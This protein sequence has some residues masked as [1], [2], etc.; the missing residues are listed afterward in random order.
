MIER[1][2]EVANI[3]RA[4]LHEMNFS[5]PHEA[6]SLQN[7]V[8]SSMMDPVLGLALRWYFVVFR[9]LQRNASTRSLNAGAASV[10]LL[11]MMSCS[12]GKLLSE[13]LHARKLR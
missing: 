7:V 1:E 8:V 11:L 5:V 6:S 3:R 4:I 2:C 12:S 10:D 13:V 9:F